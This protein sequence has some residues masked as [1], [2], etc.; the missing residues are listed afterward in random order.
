MRHTVKM[1]TVLGLTL[2][3]IAFTGG[4]ASANVAEDYRTDMANFVPVLGD[5]ADEVEQLADR[6]TA[7]PGEACSDNVA[8]L[9]RRGAG[10][11][12]DLEGTAAPAALADAHD[13]LINAFFSI[14]DATAN[15]CG[16][17]TDLA[18]EI[19]DDLADAKNALRKIGYFA[20]SAPGIVIELPVPPV[21]GN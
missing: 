7:K 12:R 16:L 10:M 13:D 9:A 14:A 8:S 20:Q 15:G 5:W 2:S 21:T 3:A 4:I 19:F 17:G 18:D 6:A 1:L 11:A